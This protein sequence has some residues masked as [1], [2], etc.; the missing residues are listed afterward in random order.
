M[1]FKKIAVFCDLKYFYKKFKKYKTWD[2][3]VWLYTVVFWAALW[4]ALSVAQ[5]LIRKQLKKLLYR[6][7]LPTI[8][9]AYLNFQNNT[10]LFFYVAD[11]L[12][13]KWTYHILLTF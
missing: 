3:K 7:G 5:Q 9:T 10:L 11:Q 12:L 6:A 13:L 8:C 1:G 2:P 4:L